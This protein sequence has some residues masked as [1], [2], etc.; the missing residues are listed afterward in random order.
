MEVDGGRNS[1][2]G[3]RRVVSAKPETSRKARIKDTGQL[4]K[5]RRFLLKDC[6]IRGSAEQRLD[7]VLDQENVATRKPVGTL[8][9]QP[10]IDVRARPQ[11]AGIK[12][13]L[14]VLVGGVLQNGVRF[15]ECEFTVAHRWKRRVRIDSH[16]SRRF[17]LALK[18]I[19][20]PEGVV[21]V[22]QLQSCQD[23]AT[24]HRYRIGVDFHKRLPFVAPLAR[25]LTP[26]R[27]AAAPTDWMEQKYK[28]RVAP[29]DGIT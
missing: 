26:R 15:P 4:V 27:E 11:F 28:I 2:V 13:R 8:P 12:S 19:D 25:S 20:F 16:V 1:D 24:V 5:I 21:D 10:S 7:A 6:W 9:E 14:T 22:H 23:L 18:I 17:L 29:A 3:D